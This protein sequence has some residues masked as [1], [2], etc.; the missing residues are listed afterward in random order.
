MLYAFSNLLCLIIGRIIG[1]RKNIIIKNLKNSFPEKNDIEI[2]KIKIDF[3]KHFCDLL[4]ESFLGF[5]ISKNKIEEKIKIN[6]QDFLNKFSNEGKNVIL[7]GGHYNNWEMSAQRLPLIS[8]H[9]VYAIYKP[10]K[11]EFFNGKVKYSREKFGLK[12]VPMKNSKKYFTN[13]T[14]KPRAII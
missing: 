5:T 3:Y 2:N 8:H 6:N 7:I 11:N 10:L 9:K 12:M 4:I 14:N 13:K 1:Y